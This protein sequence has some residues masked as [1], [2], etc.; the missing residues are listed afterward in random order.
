MLWLGSCNTATPTPRCPVSASQSHF[1]DLGS[2]TPHRGSR[3]CMVQHPERG[4]GFWAWAL[5]S[6]HL[7]RCWNHPVYYIPMDSLKHLE[8]RDGLGHEGQ[9]AARGQS[10][11]D[12]SPHP[13]GPKRQ[14]GLSWVKPCLLSWVHQLPSSSSSASAIFCAEHLAFHM[15]AGCHDACGARG[16]A[17]SW[18]A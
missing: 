11:C 1:T 4:V 8:V 13:Q 3:G 6:E 15:R 7:K 10:R 9:L 14:W 12:S 5:T 2:S 18:K 17:A 16:I